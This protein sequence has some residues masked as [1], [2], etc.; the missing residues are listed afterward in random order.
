MLGL[1]GIIRAGTAPNLNVAGTVRV[2]S[3]TSQGGGGGGGGGSVTID[4]S[5]KKGGVNANNFTLDITVA[6][7]SNRCL[8]AFY[9]GGVTNGTDEVTSISSS[10]NGAFT[11]LQRQSDSNWLDTQVW[12][13]LAPS[14]GTHTVTFTVL[15]NSTMQEGMLISLY[16]VNQSTPNDTVVA[17]TGASATPSGSAT[18][19][20][21]D[22]LVGFMN[23]E[24]GAAGSVSVQT[25]TQQQETEDIATLGDI[26]ASLATNTGSGSVTI[27]WGTA[28]VNY[29]YLLVPVNSA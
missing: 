8:Y 16:N 6:S 13:L 22:M 26:S 7:N 15:G 23:T 18:L 25:G 5:T 27:Q 4:T 3:L 11:E 2:G 28:N 10:L 14:T 9:A 12:R 29:C 21:T 20:S 24:S 19:A 17:A 1:A